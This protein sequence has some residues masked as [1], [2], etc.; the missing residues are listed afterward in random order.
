MSGSRPAVPHNFHHYSVDFPPRYWPHPLMAP[1]ELTACLPQTIMQTIS[2]SALFLKFRKDVVG[3][4]LFRLLSQ[5]ECWFSACLIENRMQKQCE[6]YRCVTES[7]AWSA[8]GGG[9][10]RFGRK[11]I[12][13]RRRKTP[14]TTPRRGL[15]SRWCAPGLITFNWIT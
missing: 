2:F 9:E 15:R 12:E 8:R 4:S 10:R 5:R 11:E 3:R 13:Q 1:P 6:I 14:R 7:S